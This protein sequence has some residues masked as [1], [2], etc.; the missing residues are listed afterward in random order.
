MRV[1]IGVSFDIL[2][3]YRFAVKE[4]P[5]HDEGAV[6]SPRKEGIVH[7]HLSGR[8]FVD[9]DKVQQLAVKRRN[10]AECRIT[11][12]GCVG[13]D[14]VENRLNRLGGIR[15]YAQHIR[16]RSLLLECLV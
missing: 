14:G 6:G 12:T 8:H 4:C 10:R 3:V 7:C 16:G 9:S 5:T 13:D 15:D 2:D 1:V 11:E